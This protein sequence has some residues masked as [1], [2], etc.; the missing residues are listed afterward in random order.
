MKFEEMNES[1][2]QDSVW[3]TLQVLAC[4]KVSAHKKDKD[5]Y[6]NYEINMRGEIRKHA[7]VHAGGRGVIVL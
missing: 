5:Y 7:R 6:K 4:E 3:E 2:K 1:N